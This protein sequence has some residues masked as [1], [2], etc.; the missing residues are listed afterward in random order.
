[1]SLPAAPLSVEQSARFTTAEREKIQRAYQLAAHHHAGQVRKSGD[2]YI[3]H[4]VAVAEI[5][6]EVG[7][8]CDFVCAALLHDVL[9]DTE[10]TSEA[11]SAE[12]GYEVAGLV[13]GMIDLDRQGDQAVLNAA[14]DRVL[15]LKVLD[16]LHNMRTLRSLTHDRQ[17]LKSRQTLDVIAPAARHLGLETIADELETLARLYLPSGTGIAGRA[18]AVGSLVLPMALRTSYLD[19]WLGELDVVRGRQARA[20]FV[21]G[22]LCGM[23]KLALFLRRSPDRIATP[24]LL[25]IARWI[26]RSNLRTWTPLVL[27][28]NWVVLEIAQNSLGEAVVALITL[29]PVLHTAVKYARAKVGLAASNE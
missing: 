14:D 17:Q 19:E 1:M 29:P 6:T 12:F 28:V 9:A 18:L 7:L 11:L 3:T 15:A 16:R 8:D 25:M 24:W 27:L 10:C 26:L 21:L 5:A 2:P 13:Q 4:P 20:R 23:P 22:L